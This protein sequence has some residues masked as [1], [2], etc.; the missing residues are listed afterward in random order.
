MLRVAEHGCAGDDEQLR[1]LVV[2]EIL[3]DRG[4]RRRAEAVE[5]EGD[6]ILLDQATDLF[7]GL[8]WTVAVVEADEIDLAAVDPALFVDHPEIGGVGAPDHAIGGGGPL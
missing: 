6:P 4:V 1:H 2:V 8:G 5:N 7:D 3:P